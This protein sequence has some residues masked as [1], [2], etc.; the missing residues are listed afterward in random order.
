MNTYQLEAVVTEDRYSQD[1]FVGVFPMDRLPKQF[2]T[3]ACMIINSASSSSQGEHW[4]AVFID[5]YGRGE[6]FDS[7]GHSADFYNQRLEDFLRRNCS[8]H[9]FN[10]REL[11][12]LWSNVCGQYCLFYFIHR[13]RQISAHDIIYQFSRNKLIN[14][15]RV[16]DFIRKHYS[17]LCKI[18]ENTHLKFF[19]NQ[20]CC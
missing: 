9:S 20:L 15:Q 19:A 12:T 4:L 18:H 2:K 14:D 8:T 17:S 5:Q 1:M 16:N 13:C 10:T 6:F 11:Q 7:Y 3:P